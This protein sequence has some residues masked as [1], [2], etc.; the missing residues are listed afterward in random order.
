MPNELVGARPIDLGAL[1]R[2]HQDDLWPALHRHGALLFRDFS[3][4]NAAAFQEA[5]RAF[6]PQLRNY[7]GGDSPR[8]AVTEKVYT[9]TTY[10]SELA[11][12]LHNEM[13]YSRDYPS[14]IAFYCDIAPLSG[15]ETPL[16]D[17]RRATGALS[18][19]L[20]E[21]FQ[22]K[23]L[24]YIQNLPNRAGIGKSWQLTF[25][26]EDRAEVEAIAAQRGATLRWRD[27]GSLRVEEI[28]DPL[29]AHPRTGDPLF[30]CQAHLW[31]SSTLDERTRRAL[32]RRTPE[33][34]LYHHCTFGDGSPLLADDLAQ[35]RRALDEAAVAIPWQRGDLLV[36]DNLL[37]AHGR[38]PFSGARRVLV[39]MG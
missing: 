2:A 10:P 16:A 29:I 5:F 20:L 31:H 14:L 13:S 1:L 28:V 6:C 37:V 38:N 24:R 22:Q 25:E 34:D 33:E 19:D 39:A 9:S 15:G 27:D 18:P 8:S 23:K 35:W 21:R 17:C 11:I 26:T 3:V 32:L 36:V 4:E 7:Q 12:P 30:F